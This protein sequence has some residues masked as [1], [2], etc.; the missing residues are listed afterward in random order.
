MD[1]L[2]ILNQCLDVILPAIASVIAILFGV[3]GAKIKRLYTDKVQDE[4][5]KTVVD[6]VVKWV[7]QVYYDLDG[8]GK[9]EKA[10]ERASQTLKE[11]GIT[12]SK[13]ELN[14]LIESAVYG[15]KQGITETTLVEGTTEELPEAVETV[16]D[17]TTTEE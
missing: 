11:K 1:W 17:V 13:S 9:L 14:T 7:Q 16:A 8:Q 6:S 2:S 4:T 12:V 15:L 10:L 3:L 5:V